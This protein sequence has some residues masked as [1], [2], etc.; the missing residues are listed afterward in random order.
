MLKL[1]RNSILTL[2]FL[3]WEPFFLD[4]HGW[5]YRRWNGRDWE[6]SPMTEDERRDAEYGHAFRG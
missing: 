2:L 5:V 3:N 1:I 4:N 6:Y